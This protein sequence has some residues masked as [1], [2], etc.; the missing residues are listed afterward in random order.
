M[1]TEP[2][3]VEVLARV[4]HDERAPTTAE[5]RRLDGSPTTRRATDGLGRR[6]GRRRSAGRA[7]V[8]C[9]ARPR[10]LPFAGMPP[11]LADRVEEILETEPEHPKPA[12]PR[13]PRSTSETAPFTLRR[14]LAT[15]KAAMAGAFAL[16]ARRDAGDAGR[17]AADPDR[18]RQGHPRQVDRSPASSP[19]CIYAVSVVVSMIASSC[20]VAWTGQVG[21]SLMYDLRV[22]VFAHL[23][24]LS[25]DFFTD[26]KAGR[27]HDPHDERHRG[28]QPAA[29][30][31][32]SCNL[33]V[34]GLTMVIVTVDPV[35]LNADARADHGAARSCP[36][37]TVA[38]AVVPQR[39]R[40]GLRAGA[41]RIAERAGRPA[42]SLS[43]IR[44]VAALQPP[45]P[46]R[47]CTTATS[48]ASTATPTTTR[49]GST[50]VYGAA[51]RVHRRRRPGAAPA[52]SAATW[53]C[54][55]TLHGR[56]ARRVRA[57]PQ[58]RSSR[59]SSSSCSCTTPTSRARRR[60]SSCDELLATHP[61][62]PERRRRRRRCRR[63]TATSRS[64]TSRSATTPGTPV[65]R[66]VDLAHRAGRD[67]RARRARPAPASRPS[68]SSSPAST[69][70]PRAACCIDGH[71]LRDV[72]LE[73]LRRQLGVV[74]QEPFL[75]AGTI[76][77]NIAFARPD[78]T[79]DEV[80][81]GR[82]R[83]SASTSSIDAAARRAR[84]ARARAGRVAVV[85]RAPAARARPRLPRPAPGA[86]ARRGHVEPRPAQS[87]TQVERGARRAARGPHRDHHRP[88]ARHRHARRPHRR[89]RRRPHR[90]ARDRTRSSRRRA[91]G[92]PTMF[93]T[94]QRHMS[95][96][97]GHASGDRNG[98][99]NGDG[100]GDGAH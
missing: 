41:R 23:Q 11:E 98:H 65:L 67:V 90:R 62:V 61:T 25:L 82:A 38:D 45:A 22:R 46:Q 43:G 68:P 27:D 14:F 74:P 9:R 59:R 33:A 95:G 52:R 94:W 69:T 21:E 1:A 13:S 30:R 57:L 10:G 96:H 66:D 85:G 15:R 56:R 87:E 12:R 79:D 64:T 31:T 70:R 76:R 48:S 100:N 93:D 50:R 73:S 7:A 5:A 2:R 86:R 29:S 75:F 19:R 16:V 84:H 24:R 71:D 77:D 4:E 32:A 88:P 78:A 63:S 54:N 51:H 99:G 28:A 35:L 89:R 72:T 17:P 40:P 80:D 6:V 91:A 44:I 58:L 20:R 42:E 47:A 8:A 60:S 37:M 83:A 97:N 81:G 34:Q 36:L 53:C 26:E 18:H 3:Y 92:T 39:V 55:G 49:R